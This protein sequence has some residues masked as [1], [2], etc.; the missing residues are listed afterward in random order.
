V[1]EAAGPLSGGGFP[2]RRRPD[3]VGTRLSVFCFQK[4]KTDVPRNTD[5]SAGTLIA[6]KV[7]LPFQLLPIWMVIP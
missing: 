6:E 7:V 5:A 4:Q 3:G 1:S 2:S